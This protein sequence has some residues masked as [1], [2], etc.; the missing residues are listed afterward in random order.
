[1]R[2]SV[3]SKEVDVLVTDDK[4]NIIFKS[5]VE[6]YNVEFDSSNIVNVADEF[7][8]IAEHFKKITE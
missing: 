5:S 7:V 6:N 8:A 4:G 2:V 1:M 3:S